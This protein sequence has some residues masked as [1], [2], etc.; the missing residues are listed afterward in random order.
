M[1]AHAVKRPLWS[2]TLDPFKAPIVRLLE[3][4][5]YA[6]AQVFQRLREH[7]FDGD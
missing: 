4:Y 3:R 7:G 2:R 1:T 6:A 5:P